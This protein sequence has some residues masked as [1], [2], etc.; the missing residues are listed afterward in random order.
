MLVAKTA[1]EKVVKTVELLVEK[2][3]VCLVVSSVGKTVACSVVPKAAYWVAL[4][5]VSSVDLR[6]E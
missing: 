6:A 5:A 4:W 3:A 1:V 2:L